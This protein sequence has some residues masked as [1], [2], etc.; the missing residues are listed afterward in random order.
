MDALG[1]GKIL[2]ATTVSLLATTAYAQQ[3]YVK[4]GANPQGFA[5]DKLAC[6]Q[7]AQMAGG[8]GYFVYGSPLFVML[9]EAI[10]DART[11][12]QRARTFRRSGHLKFPRPA[13]MVFGD[14][15]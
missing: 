15:P 13:A 5:Q 14:Q 12:C 3:L 11:S 1:K 6:M 4:P 7:T 2:L 10:N 8:G 9:S